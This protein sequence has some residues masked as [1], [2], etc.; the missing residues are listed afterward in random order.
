MAAVDAGEQPWLAGVGQGVGSQRERLIL[1]EGQN[2]TK[3]L[4]GEARKVVADAEESTK[5]GIN[6]RSF[7]G[8]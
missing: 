1:S 7:R 5:M 2:K 4:V 8:D 3:P 6:E